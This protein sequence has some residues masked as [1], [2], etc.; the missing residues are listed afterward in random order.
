MCR[1]S[2]PAHLQVSQ[3][4]MHR[5]LA[6]ACEHANGQVREG[7]RRRDLRPHVGGAADAFCRMRE[8]DLMDKQQVLQSYN[9]W[10]SP[11]CT[12]VLPQ[13]LSTAYVSTQ[14]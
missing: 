5:G 10:T 4:S 9:G 13:M 8:H 12:S 3:S 7:R 14:F 11:A 1:A 2:R 6:H